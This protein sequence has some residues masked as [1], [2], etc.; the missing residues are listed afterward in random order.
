MATSGR[1]G[2]SVSRVSEESCH[3]LLIAAIRRARARTAASLAIVYLCVQASVCYASSKNSRPSA[4]ITAA[5]R[6]DCVS[7]PA[8]QVAGALQG[9]SKTPAR[10]Q[11]HHCI[12]LKFG[13]S[14]RAQPSESASHRRDARRA[15]TARSPPPAQRSINNSTDTVNSS[16]RLRQSHRKRDG[17]RAAPRSRATAT[18][19]R[20]KQSKKARS[21]RARPPSGSPSKLERIPTRR[22]NSGVT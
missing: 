15:P 12:S 19:S 14:A 9:G 7:H 5:G 6:I 1:S 16:N 18:S 20:A 10:A 11:L 3:R 22:Q 17:G 8:V 2:G 13:S 4:K 21:S